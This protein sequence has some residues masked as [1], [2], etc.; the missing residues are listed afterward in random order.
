MKFMHP[1]NISLIILSGYGLEALYRRYFSQP[2]PRT[3]SRPQSK[4][5]WWQKASGFEK[6]WVIGSG[7]ALIAAV[8]GFFIGAV[9]AARTS[10]ITSSTTDSTMRTWL[11]RSPASA[12]AKWVCSSFIWPC[13]PAWLLFI[14]SGHWPA[15][16]LSGPG[17]CLERHYDLRSLPRRCPVDSVL[18]LQGKVSLNP[19]VEILRQKPWEHRVVS[20]TS[21][22]GPYDLG[23]DPNFG[24]VPLVAGE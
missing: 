14:L 24:G 15:G 11:D 6:K 13:P 7:I 18:Q 2:P 4:L 9:L 20:R 22:I 3:G 8:A 17:S 5:N 19:V 1:L 12:R 21:P 16:A 23:T 10:S